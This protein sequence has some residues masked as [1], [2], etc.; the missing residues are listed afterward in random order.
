[1]TDVYR[2]TGQA[3]VSVRAQATVLTL[4]LRVFSV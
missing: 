4:R 3:W 1:M 2:L